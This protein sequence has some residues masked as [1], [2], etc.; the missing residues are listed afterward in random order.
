MS[1]VGSIGKWIFCI[2]GCLYSATT[3]VLVNGSPIVEFYLHI[4]LNQG[5][6]T[7]SSLF[8]HVM[9]GLHVVVEYVIVVGFFR[10][11]KVHSMQISYLL[12][13]YVLF[14]GK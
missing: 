7:S 10:G 13:D 4:G 12:V 14:L 6:H 3:L 5:D 9:E 1:F 2:H 11:T 8:I